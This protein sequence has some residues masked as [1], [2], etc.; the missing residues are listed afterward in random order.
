MGMGV[1]VVAPWTDKQVEALNKFQRLGY[2]HEFTC[3]ESHRE[4]RTLVA[5][6]DG[7]ACP[8]CSYRQAWAYDYMADETRHPD[9]PL[10]IFRMKQK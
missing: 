7:W 9:N 6:H 3:P 8:S 4:S 5:T 10:D 1:T 2:V